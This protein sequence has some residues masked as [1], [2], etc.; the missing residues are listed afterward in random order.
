MNDL[1]YFPKSGYPNPDYGKRWGH[2]NGNWDPYVMG[3]GNPG[4]GCG[5]CG[6]LILIVVAVVILVILQDATYH[7]ATRKSP[8]PAKTQSVLVLPVH[9]AG[10]SWGERGPIQM[11]S[12]AGGVCPSCLPPL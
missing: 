5:C 4:G 12:R 1:P 6:C 2:P 11:D 10:L 3:S 9:E 7:P 8:L